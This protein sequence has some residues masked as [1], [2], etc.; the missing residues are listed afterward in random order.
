MINHLKFEN[1]LLAFLLFSIRK[2]A[3]ATSKEHWLHQSVC[4]NQEFC[5]NRLNDTRNVSITQDTPDLGP[6]PNNKMRR[7]KEFEYPT[8]VIE[9][10]EII[11]LCQSQPSVSTPDGQL[12]IF[13]Q[14]QQQPS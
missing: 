3:K 11:N 5:G 7:C 12:Q 14:K 4:L 1:K 10:T 13:L 6:N 8:Q 9:K 2:G